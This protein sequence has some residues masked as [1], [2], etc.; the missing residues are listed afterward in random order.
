MAEVSP[1]EI[2]QFQ[3]SAEELQKKVSNKIRYLQTL[4]NA[5][6]AH[7][8]RLIYQLIDG[9]NYSHQIM[10]AKHGTA[11]AGNERLLN[12]VTAQ[13]SQYL[14]IN[15]LSYLKET[16]P[17]FYFQQT[18]LGNYQFFFGN[19]WDR[20]LFG[21]LDI[22][23]VA[24]EFDEI[25]YQKLKRAFELEQENKRLNSDQIAVI[26]QQTDQLQALI[27]SQAERDQQKEKIRQQ[28]KQLAQEKVLP[29][30]ASKI[31]ENKQQ[32]VSQLSELTDQDEKAQKAYKLIRE[33]QKDVLKLS[34]EDT[35]IGYEKQSIVAKFGSFE[36][37]E[38]RNKS[39][40]RD[41]IA[42]LIATKGRVKIEN[43]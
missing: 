10:Q 31:R 26:S 36:N 7:D 27:N 32:L 30:E 24:F 6:Q 5:V 23:K 18:G 29:W 28:L 35:L 16:Y 19:W 34:K 8:D 17:F 4:L 38:A 22:L 9:E 39:L 42:D 20:R 43:E 41:Y 1:V 25:E 33:S 14:S 40:Y 2:E 13:I 37:F 15:L 21:T 11:D 3:Q 12:D